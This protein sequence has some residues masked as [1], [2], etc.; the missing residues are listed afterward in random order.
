MD[1]V[2]WSKIAIEK[3][4]ELKVIDGYGDGKFMPN[5]YVTREEF[6]K[7]IVMAFEIYNDN[8]ESNFNDVLKSEWYYKYVSSAFENG[9]VK[10]N[11]HDVFGVGVHLS[12]QHMDVMLKREK[13]ELQIKSN[14]EEIIF[15]DFEEVDAYAKEAVSF[16]SSHGIINGM[17]NR[18]FVPLENVTRAQCAKA[19]YE[20]LILIGGRQ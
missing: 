5:N 2:D 19:I 15:N 8:A 11:N 3:L 10:G 16:L 17:G 9:I 1:G 6:V 7:M 14:A 20:S 12:R 13:S 18:L 4:Y